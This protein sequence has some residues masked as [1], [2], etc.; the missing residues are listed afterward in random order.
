MKRAFDITSTLYS[1]L[2]DYEG[3]ISLFL[4]NQFAGFDLIK[5]NGKTDHLDE[6]LN[7][8]SKFFSAK[9]DINRL[10]Y[11]Q[12]VA[13]MILMIHNV[14]DLWNIREIVA[15]QELMRKINYEKQQD[16]TIHTLYVYMLGVWYYDNIPLIKECFKN[17]YSIDESSHIEKFHFRWIYSSLL[18]DLGYVYYDLKRK[19]HIQL[20]EIANIFSFDWLIKEIASHVLNCICPEELF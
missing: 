8:L 3:G 1:H 6:Y 10:K 18:H 16:H 13:K 19:N 9:T 11:S 2:L 7:S 12:D 17:K 5:K 20:S 14:E 15:N 4:R